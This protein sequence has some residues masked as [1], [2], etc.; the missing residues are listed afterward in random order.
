MVTTLKD[1]DLALEAGSAFLRVHG[2]QTIISSF[3]FD[4][5]NFGV[6]SSFSTMNDRMKKG[7]N[8]RACRFSRVVEFS[9]MRECP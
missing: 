9:R 7:R 8:A 5:E 6:K 2:F 1:D 4:L 3:V